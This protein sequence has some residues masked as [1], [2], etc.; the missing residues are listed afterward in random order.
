MNNY[1]TYTGNEPI[2]YRGNINHMI[3]I[4]IAGKDKQYRVI[5][6]SREIKEVGGQWAF[7]FMNRECE[8]VFHYHLEEIKIVKVKSKEEI[9]AEESLAKAKEA[10]KAAENALKVVKEQ[11]K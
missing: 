2:E 1:I 8:V 11:I 10:L 3:N 9:A 7:G 4:N 6:E 5:S